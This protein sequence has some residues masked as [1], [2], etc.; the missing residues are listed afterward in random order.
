MNRPPNFNRLAGLYRWMEFFSFGPRLA[1]TRRAFLAQL[2]HSRRALVLGDGD[3][4]FTA[5]ML[6]E[7]ADIQVDA[8]DASAA[9]LEELLR[10]A[11]PHAGRVHIH[12]ADVRTW[13]LP[14]PI[15]APAYDLI[16]THFFLDCLTA[17]E[18]Q[19]LAARL[20]AAAS[21]STLWVVSEFAIPAGWRGRLIARPL[22][23]SLYFAFG[24]LTGLAVRTLPDHQD[25]L[26]R[27]GF[28][29]VERQ[30][31][32]GGLLI[33]ELWSVN[34]QDLAPAALG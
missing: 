13:Q 26:R 5:R 23:A 18:I 6:R 2:A 11:G 16:A 25:A 3:G 4:R 12:L 1:L 10:R 19:S 17:H 33:A 7:N 22:V 21:P 24:L 29:L 8:V 20:H 14:A 31:R 30:S 9:M 32:L 34:P 15:A 28:K 27:A